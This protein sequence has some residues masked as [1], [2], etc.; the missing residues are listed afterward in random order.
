[1]GFRILIPQDITQCGKDYLL[2][3]GYEVKIG[4]KYFYSRPDGRCCWL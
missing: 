2:E 4:K 3:N 1:M